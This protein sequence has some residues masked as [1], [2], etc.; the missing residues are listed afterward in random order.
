M[1]C[2][3]D[4]QCA[5]QAFCQTMGN[6]QAQTGTT[7]VSPCRTLERLKEFFCRDSLMPIPGLLMSIDDDSIIEKTPDKKSH[8]PKAGSGRSV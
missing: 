3:F 8:S 2:I 7:V 6:I 1:Q 5:L 4:S